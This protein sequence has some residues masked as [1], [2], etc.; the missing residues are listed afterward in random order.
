MNKNDWTNKL[1]ERLADYQE[2]VKHD[3]WVNIEQ[4]LNKKPAVYTVH[5]RRISIAAALAALVVGGTYLYFNPSEQE[6]TFAP[7]KRY[8]VQAPTMESQENP[9]AAQVL[10]S[11]IKAVFHDGTNKKEETE[12]ML[13]CEL[14]LASIPEVTNTSVKES[15]DEQA[16]SKEEP[17][18]HSTRTIYDASPYSYKEKSHDSKWSVKVYGENGFIHNSVSS[19]NASY[20]MYSSVPA[21]FDGSVTTTDLMEVKK[22]FVLAGKETKKTAKHHQPLSMGVQVGFRLKSN[23]TLATG[24]VYTRA[25]SE[26]YEEDGGGQST[27]FQTLHYIGIPLNVIYDVWG[28]QRFHTYVT[29]G[30]EGDVNVK[31]HTEKDGMK[32]E[33]KND[34]MQWS[35]NTSVGVQYDILPQLGI[36]V[37]PGVKYYFN[38]GSIVE[39]TFKDKKL[40]FNFQFG[41]R[42]NVGKE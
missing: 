33:G 5:F 28:T 17:I 2:P 35:A 1:R 10:A 38:N 16:I 20:P 36:Y 32:I 21:P 37:E 13:D 24:V 31:I 18:S 11:A 26:F 6:A 27:T 22:F 40:N 19:N 34:R 15:Q 25:N 30:G 14:A 4:S 8:S 29:V 3:L 41:L 42:W 39:N 12:R 23:L 7:I 9:Q